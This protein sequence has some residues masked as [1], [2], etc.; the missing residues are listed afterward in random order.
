M[1]DADDEL[2]AAREQSAASHEILAALSRDTADPG[3]VLDTIVEYAARLCGA[4][5]A[6]LF[7]VDG[8]G[9]RLSRV[10]GATPEEYREYL[11]NH[12]IARNRSSTV[13]RAA[14]DRRTHQVADVL[15]DADY[16]RLDLQR[17]TGFR[18]LLSTP[19]LSEDEVVGVL[20]MWRIDV[21]PFDE[22]ERE[23]LEEFAV[24][25]AIALRQVHLMRALEARRSELADKVAQL[26][27]LQQVDDAVGSSLDLD[28][29][30]ERIVSNAVRL[31]NLGFGDTT[32]RTDGGSILDYDDRA[33]TFAVRDTT[34]T[35]RRLLEQLRTISIDR[36][37]LLIGQAARTLRP[38]SV[39]DLAH[40]QRDA[41]LEIVFGDGWRSVLAVPMLRGDT[42]VGVLV[43]RR[44]GTGDFPS[45][46]TDLLETFANQS[47]LAIVNAR[48]YRELETRSRELE[49]AS[50]HKSEFLASMSHELRT[51]LNAVIG[52]S[53]VLL[54]GMFG[55]INSQQEEYLR[56]IWNS[57]RHLLELLN[58]ILDLSKVEAGHMVLEPSTF[59]V[60]GA[61]KDTLAMIR[62]RA[63]AHRISM[64]VELADDVEV[65]E[66]DELRFKQVLLNLV[67]NAV[68]FTP[69]GGSVSLCVRGDGPDLIITVTDTGIGVAPEDQDRIFESF[70]QGRRGPSKGEGTGLGLTLSRRIV[71]LFGGRMWLNST[72]GAGSTFGF[73]I[74]VLPTT[75][76][77]PDEVTVAAPSRGPVLVLVDDDRASLD[78]IEAYLVGSRARVLKAHDGIDA[79]ELIRRVRPA[80]V[81]LDIKLPRLDG[82]HVLAE[83][84]SDPVTAGVP[85]V[86]ASVID[87]RP[88]ALALGADAYLLKPVS[89][90]ELLTALQRILGERRRR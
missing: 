40:A 35:S 50:S 84:K 71:E 30:L 81:V 53:E 65:I 17:L 78:L 70:Q 26:E 73:S 86:I 18:T 3:A 74:P 37:S 34:G 75:P 45:D 56:D 63:A 77:I 61:V 8:D 80:G 79:L 24:Q 23:R 6:Q 88:R 72:V 16:G 66:A 36:S 82:W 29:V 69:D 51:P 2:R 28:E 85:V 52:F 90:E 83:L 11:A 39:S 7:V 47:A 10:S 38:C 9:F 25:G 14:E 68:K 54:D 5:A 33:G 46:V 55:E 49:I 42:L 4:T 41:F 27:A 15:S 64:S 19:L 32:L 20:S 13:G 44:R 58:E 59:P 1:T 57:G 62:D 22:R 67:T 76:T 43:I 31:T 12:P 60:A 21:D 89:R 48:L 87:D